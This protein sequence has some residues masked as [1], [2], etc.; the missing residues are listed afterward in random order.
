MRRLSD[1]IDGRALAVARI[2][3]GVAALINLVEVQMKIDHVLFNETLRMPM[4]TWLPNLSTGLMTFASALGVMAAVAVV[5]GVFTRS[6]A[7]SLCVLLMALLAWEQQV[8]SNHLVLSAWCLLWLALSRADARWSFA[9]RIR[10]PRDVTFADQLLLMTQLSVVYLFTGSLKVNEHFL[11]G[12]VIQEWSHLVLPGWT[13]TAMAGAAVATE[14]SLAV[15]LWIPRVR[16][17]VAAA[18]L[19]LHLTIPFVMI[20]PAPLLTFSLL[21]LSLYPLF[22]VRSRPVEDLVAVGPD[23]VAIARA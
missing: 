21:M 9:A 12:R 10:G 19:G 22:L 3:I 4:W 8:Y 14:V 18:G 7:L 2:G 17:I 11:S 16:W 1:V 20:M 23:L 5:C 6:A 13:W 15:G